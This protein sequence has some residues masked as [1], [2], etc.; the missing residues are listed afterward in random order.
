M[1]P[2]LAHGALGIWDEVIFVG[3]AVVFI[4]MM[5]MSWYRSQHLPPEDLPPEAVPEGPPTDG[6]RFELR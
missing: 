3:V 6:E 5:G 2:V 4:V 1:F